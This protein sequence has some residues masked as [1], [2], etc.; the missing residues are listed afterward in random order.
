MIE[1]VGEKIYKEWRGDHRSLSFWPHTHTH[2]QCL[3]G[4]KLMCW[5]FIT[6]FA[7]FPENNWE[8]ENML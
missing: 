4:D 7:I 8:N 2:T 3:H 5:K 1:N 6:L